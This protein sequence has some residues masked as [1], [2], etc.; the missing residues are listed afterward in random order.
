MFSKNIY[1]GKY[2]EEVAGVFTYGYK[3]L[4]KNLYCFCLQGR[5]RDQNTSRCIILCTYFVIH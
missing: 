2:F 5:V 4:L 3:Q 1:I